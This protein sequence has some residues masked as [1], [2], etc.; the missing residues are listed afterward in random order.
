MSKKMKQGRM[1]SEHPNDSCITGGKK[2]HQKN[3]S[4]MPS[5]LSSSLDLLSHPLL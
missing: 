3:H 2:L 4:I 5:F 1:K